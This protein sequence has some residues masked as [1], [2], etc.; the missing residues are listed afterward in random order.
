MRVRCGW[1]LAIVGLVETAS[2]QDIVRPREFIM[3]QPGPFRPAPMVMAPINVQ[4]LAQQQ[5]TWTANNPQAVT[6]KPLKPQAQVP[7]GNH[8]QSDQFQTWQFQSH[9]W[10]AGDSTRPAA[11]ARNSVLHRQTLD[12]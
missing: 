3:L 10:N 12:W 11:Q 8:W 5:W 7:Q 4:P 1:A 2:A 6:M 9:N